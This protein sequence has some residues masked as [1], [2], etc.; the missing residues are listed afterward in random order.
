MNAA[1][2]P[3]AGWSLGV[4]A[5]RCPPPLPASGISTPAVFAEPTMLVTG[6]PSGDQPPAASPLPAPEGMDPALRK[7]VWLL[8]GGGG[9]L[10]VV[11]LVFLLILAWPKTG[12]G[13]KGSGGQEPVAAGST[14]PRKEQPKGPSST[15]PSLLIDEDFVQAARDMKLPDGWEGDDFKAVVEKDRPCLVS[16]A[17]SGH[18]FVT[19]PH[20]LPLKGNFTI[21]GRYLLG[22]SPW[23]QHLT[24][25]LDSEKNQARLTVAID[26]GGWV[27]ID[28]GRNFPKYTPSDDTY[29]RLT[30]KGNELTVLLDDHPIVQKR[31]DKVVEYDTVQIG[32]TAGGGAVPGRRPTDKTGG[33]PAHV[34][35]LYFLKISLLPP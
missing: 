29:F 27:I 35:R 18:H 17:A 11:G 24:I 23:D 13:D 21:W 9:G 34:A 10:V 25:R 16:T 32:L 30:C 6:Q 5:T 33:K 31:L 15:D 28:G 19:L 3:E 14:Q 26:P 7:R 4:E 20:P 2:A 1:G 12:G 8:L 22:S